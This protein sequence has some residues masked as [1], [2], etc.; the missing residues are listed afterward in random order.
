MLTVIPVTARACTDCGVIAD[1]RDMDE[2]FTGNK[3]TRRCEKCFRRYDKRL[4]NRLLGA[5]HMIMDTVVSLVRP[6]DRL[7]QLGRYRW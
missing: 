1:I 2:M 6:S 5:V 7:A 4:S 3:I